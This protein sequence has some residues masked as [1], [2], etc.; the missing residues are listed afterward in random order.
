[1]N[2]HHERTGPLT[3]VLSLTL[4]ESEWRDLLEAEPEPIAWLREQIRE[5]LNDSRSTVASRG[6]ADGSTDAC[7]H[8]A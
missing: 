2:G 1:M 5:R 7:G 8:L 3:R 4:P 6:T